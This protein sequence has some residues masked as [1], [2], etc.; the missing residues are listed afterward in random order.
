MGG[1]RLVLALMLLVAATPRGVLAGEA[2]AGPKG[3]A[4]P[5]FPPTSGLDGLRGAIR[6]LPDGRIELYYDWR[7]P[8][9]LADWQALAGGP[10]QV[11]DGEL[12]L[13][14]EESHTLRHVAPFLGAV[15]AGGTCRA[16]EALGN[17][18]HCAVALHAG[19]WRGYWLNLRPRQQELYR[20]DDRATVLDTTD[21]RLRAGTPHTFHFARFGNLLRA[22]LD[23]TV[24]MRASDATYHQGAV[25]LRA[26]RVRAGVRG[27]WLLGRLDPQWLAANPKVAQQLDALRLY[28]AGLAAL[29]P[30]WQAGQWTEAT[31]KAKS[32]AAAEPYAKCPAAAR[33]LVEDAEASAALWQA[34]E[35]GI[36]RLKP[37]DAVRADGADAVFSRYERGIL[38]LLRDGV[39]LAKRPAALQG[40]EL[41][42]LVARARKVEEGRDRLALALLRLHAAE[43]RRAAAAEELALA[44]RA[45]ADTARHWGLLI[46]RPP[47]AEKLVPTQYAAGERLAFSGKPLFIEAESAAQVLGAMQVARDEAASG[48]RFVWEPRE[49][50]EGQYGKPASRVVFLIIAQEPRSVYLWARVRSETA[51]ANSFLFALAPE[52]AESPNLRPWHLAPRPGWHW[53]PYN[54]ASGVDAGSTRPS[55]LQ[56]QPGVNS[57]IIATRERAVGL[58]KLYLSESPEAPGP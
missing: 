1:S 54:A 27:L 19:P 35:A 31:A 16:I 34:V 46:P 7:D 58:D 49:D 44:A 9:Q 41:L 40:D 5:S 53:E 51:D 10:P 3:D 14:G 50:G 21:A 20:E 24:A 6:P 57:L 11:A 15:E 56:L 33:H 4:A 22:W 23:Q 48:A 47:T 26:W 29:R 8:A 25:L 13:G 39:E 32:L 55:P 30:L 28:Y 2:A 17:N 52:G 45:G 42:A 43:P 12:R 18:G 37:G 38:S 36:G